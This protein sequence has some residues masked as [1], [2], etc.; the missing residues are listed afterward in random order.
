[1]YRRILRFVVH[2]FHEC[3]TYT[4]VRFSVLT[5]NVNFAKIDT[6][7]GAID[8]RLCDS[9]SGECFVIAAPSVYA[10]HNDTKL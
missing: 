2:K 6:C 7:I 4:F 10:V 9:P 1:M 3:F 5:E 8:T